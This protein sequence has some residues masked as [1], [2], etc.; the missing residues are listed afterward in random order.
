MMW[1]T[2]EQ[3]T[4]K[5]GLKPGV[6]LLAICQLLKGR[7]SI[8]SLVQLKTRMLSSACPQRKN[9]IFDIISYGYIDFP[10]SLV[11][12]TTTTIVKTN[13]IINTIVTYQFPGGMI[14]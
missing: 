9:D 10:Q 5:H 1:T 12:L 6:T 8:H 7:K 11:F 3:F 4:V 14:P 2:C 13:S